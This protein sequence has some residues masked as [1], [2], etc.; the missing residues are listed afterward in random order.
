M[1]S[2]APRTGAEPNRSDERPRAERVDMRNV[3]IDII[4]GICI[5]AMVYGHSFGPGYRFFYL[6]HMALFV[7]AS[8]YFFK[9]AASQSLHNLK[10]FFIRKI[11]ALWVPFVITG[12]TFAVLHNV[13][14]YCN[15]YT[16]N[17]ALLDVVKTPLTRLQ[18]YASL[19][20]T[21]KSIA[22]TL[23][24]TC[25]SELATAQWFL[26]ALCLVSL[27]YGTM[28]YLLTRTRW[29]RDKK[30]LCHLTV[31]LVFLCIG[32]GVV[33]KVS[34]LAFYVTQTL[35]LY[36]LFAAGYV[37]GSFKEPDLKTPAKV[38]L[39]FIALAGLLFLYSRG[40]IELAVNEYPSVPFFVAAS[41]LGW[42]LVKCSASFIKKNSILCAA[43]ATC[44]KH[45]LSILLLHLAV[46]KIINACL[47]YVCAYPRF[48]IAGFPTLNIHDALG[49]GL[50]YTAGG[51]GV[52]VLCAVLWEKRPRG[53]RALPKAVPPTAH[54]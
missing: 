31:S 24:F 10:I 42:I 44:G 5:V 25:S 53:L 54:E 2:G 50:L 19:L 12:V 15:V 27:L 34:S 13:F 17:A 49:L 26:R 40:N 41:L 38:C 48:M 23:A 14:M 47:V 39:W 33:V 8:G 3:E 32:H 6:F 36:W 1:R 37:L 43:L 11:K 35:S 28:D 30:N 46:F 9:D 45:S 51:V 52:P 7:I 18:H 29:T 16:D 22:R 21:A 20:D 4:K